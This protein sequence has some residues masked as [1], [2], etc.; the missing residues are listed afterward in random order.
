MAH[1]GGRPPK[2]KTVK[3]LK[4]WVD[5]YFK[6]CE[7]NKKRPKLTGMNEFLGVWPGYFTDSSNENGAEFTKI[8]RGAQAKIA[9]FYENA[10]DDKQTCPALGIFMLKNCGYADRVEVNA[11]ITDN[12]SL[13]DL[14][15]AVR[16]KRAKQ[17][18][19]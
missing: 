13:G 9:G 12:S 6:D 11:N 7:K 8:I 17:G 1:A 16:D 4:Y 3:Q 14:S 18:K 15:K 5:L 10:I 19:R 2:Y